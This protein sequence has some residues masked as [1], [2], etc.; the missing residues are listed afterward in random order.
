MKDK[1][2]QYVDLLF[3]GAEDAEDIKEEILQNTLD[4]YNDLIDQGKSPEA[5]YRLAI[6]GIGDVNEILA[7][8]LQQSHKDNPD[9]QH[10]ITEIVNEIQRRKMRAAAVAFYILC[11]VPLFILGNIG[12]GV[13]GLCMMFLL[14]AAATALLILAPKDPEDASKKE[15]DE[16]EGEEKFRNI[17]P[18]LKK[19]IDTL[20]LVLFFAL[21]FTTQAWHV[22]WLVFPI[23]SCVFH[24]ITAIQDLKEEKKHEV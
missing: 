7:G 3:A 17:N 10:S 1:L 18:E 11:P 5:A 14:I 12:S 23:K 21:S 15:K 8:G 16:D 2:T 24:L 4:K 22:T 9:P 6:S 20:T 13:I 19:L